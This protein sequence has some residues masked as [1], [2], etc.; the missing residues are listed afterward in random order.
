MQKSLQKSQA[1]LLLLEILRSRDI[2]AGLCRMD[3]GVSAKID[4]MESRARESSRC[5]YVASYV[6]VG[7]NPYQVAG[8]LVIKKVQGNT[9]MQIRD[10]YMYVVRVVPPTVRVGIIAANAARASS[11]GRQKRTM[12]SCAL[13]PSSLGKVVGCL[14]TQPQHFGRQRYYVASIAAPV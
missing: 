3:G 10:R 7:M 12:A 9:C 13:A 1:T 4:R 6:H 8:I 14:L 2:I 5:Y 11:A